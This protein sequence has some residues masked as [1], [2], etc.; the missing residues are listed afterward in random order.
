MAAKK[1]AKTTKKT[2][3]TK[4]TK[5]AKTPFCSTAGR[6]LAASQNKNLPR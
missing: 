1:T 2:N 6:L 5:Q 3:G 4:A